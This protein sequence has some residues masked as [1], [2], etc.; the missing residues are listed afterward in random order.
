[1]IKYI[2]NKDLQIIEVTYDGDINTEDLF[3]LTKY[4]RD[5]NK[6]PR[7]LKVLVDVSNGNYNFNPNT[8]VNL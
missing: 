7:K 4:I 1:M 5:D 8:V 2:F 3:K 6:L